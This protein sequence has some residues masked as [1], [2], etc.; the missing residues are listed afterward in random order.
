MTVREAIASLNEEEYDAWFE[1]RMRRRDRMRRAITVL[2]V[3]GMIAGAV[4]LTFEFVE[5]FCGEDSL[6]TQIF[7]SAMVLYCGWTVW[8]YLGQRDEPDEDDDRFEY[9]E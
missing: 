5:I 6:P 4:S 9:Y 7:L 1:R 8:R 3:M 2:S